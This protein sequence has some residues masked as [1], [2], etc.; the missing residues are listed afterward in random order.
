MSPA[1]EL[2][3]MAEIAHYDVESDFTDYKVSL[4]PEKAQ[5]WVWKRSGRSGNS[6]LQEIKH[7]SATFKRVLRDLRAR[8]EPGSLAAEQLD[9]CAD[10]ART[11][12]L[13]GG[14]RIGTV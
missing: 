7:N 9:R 4:Y 8:C 10:T 13:N 12:R 1:K 3:K 2:G 11:V 5:V 6:W 14:R